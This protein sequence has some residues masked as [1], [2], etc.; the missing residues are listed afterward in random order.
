[1]NAIS[2]FIARW[3]KKPS[4]APTVFT[5]IAHPDY[6]ASTS[7]EQMRAD[8]AE[9]FAL[10][11]F[12]RDSYGERSYASYLK[13]LDSLWNAIEAREKLASCHA[14]EQ[15]ALQCFDASYQSQQHRL[16]N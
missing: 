12:V 8:H 3:R 10:R 1:M 14:A 9:C 5:R 7:I 2:R 6:A 11:Q 16:L 4:Q 13:A 15:M